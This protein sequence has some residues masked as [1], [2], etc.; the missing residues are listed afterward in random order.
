M[1]W[2]VARANTFI[3]C[4]TVSQRATGST[5]TLGYGVVE[6]DD[7][8][9]A[10]GDAFALD[11]KAMQLTYLAQ[12]AAEGQWPGHMSLHEDAGRLYE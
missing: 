3:A 8:R 7:E 10:A 2:V 11:A 1:A 5:P 9:E 12:I 4:G 6:I